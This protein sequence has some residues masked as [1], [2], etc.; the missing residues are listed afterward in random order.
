MKMQLGNFIK[1]YRIDNELSLRMFAKKC[2]L[3]YTYISKLEDGIDS[4]TNKPVIPTIDTL[5]KIA[6][7]TNTPLSHI[8]E[9]SGYKLNN[10]N[11]YS[12]HKLKDHLIGE[13]TI[14]LDN[15]INNTTD[16]DEDLSK[17]FD[18]IDSS[19]NLIWQGKPLT[20]EIRHELKGALRFLTN[21]VKEK[22]DKEDK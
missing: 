1:N 12:G 7:A 15:Y 6:D 8:I 17:L 5:S 19:K 3:S 18:K 9:L 14:E 11:K 21:M 20:D 22:T 2:A 10:S 13:D 4:R 16:I